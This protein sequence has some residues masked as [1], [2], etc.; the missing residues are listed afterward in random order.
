[1]SLKEQKKKWWNGFR[2]VST[3]ETTMMDLE[4]STLVENYGIPR[5]LCKH[6]LDDI[7][8]ANEKQ[9]IVINHM[10]NLVHDWKGT[11]STMIVTGGNGTGK[12]MLGAALV[13]SLAIEDAVNNGLRISSRYTDEASL[14]MR[15]TGFDTSG[16]FDLFARKI[17]LLVID[18]FAMTQWSPADKKKIEQYLGVRYGN[19]LKTIIFT[20]RTADELFGAGG[21]EAIL[22]SQLRSRYGS[23]Y[24]VDMNG[25]DYRR[26]PDALKRAIESGG[27]SEDW[28]F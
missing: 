11:P 14:T 27:H 18:E 19:N 22:S 25:V 24:L 2:V 26:N 7:V 20:N 23:G 15:L 12:S 6:T 28:L 8:P 4:P 1:M 13:H 3:G 5:S 17:S 16:T 10:Y 9:L 21:Q